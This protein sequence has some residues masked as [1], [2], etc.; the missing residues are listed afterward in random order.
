MLRCRTK[1]LAGDNDMFGPEG[2]EMEEQF[3]HLKVWSQQ[4][5]IFNS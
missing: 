3:Y 2:F 1:M 5:R 4:E